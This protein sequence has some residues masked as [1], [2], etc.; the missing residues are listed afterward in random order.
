MSTSNFWEWMEKNNYGHV[1]ED[2]ECIYHKNKEILN[3][4]PILLEGYLNKYLRENS[5][6]EIFEIDGYWKDDKSEFS[7]YLIKSTHEILEEEDDSIFHY[8]LSEQDI[9]KTIKEGNNNID[10]AITAYRKIS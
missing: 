10:F 3:P 4:S 6:C 2:Y 9:Q 5:T 7:S 1:G 8:G